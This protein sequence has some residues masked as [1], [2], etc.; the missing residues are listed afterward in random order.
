[1]VTVRDGSTGRVDLNKYPKIARLPNHLKQFMVD[2][3]Y[4]DYTPVDHA[5]WRYIMRQA[6]HILRE[7]AHRVYF[8]GLLDTGISLERIPRIEEMNEILGRIGWGAVAVDGFI[9]PAAFMEY[10]AY[11]VLVIACDMRQINHIEYT[12]APD[13]VHEAAGHA[14][15]IVDQEY[16]EYLR[17]FGEIGAKAMSSKKDFDLYEAI[18]LLS[19]LKE[20]P[21]ADAGEIRKAEE[22][23]VWLQNNLG[24]PSE[25]ARLSRLHWWTVEYGLIGDLSKS[26][27]YGAGLL[28]SIGEAVSCLED[29]VRKL[30]YAL[31][32]ADFAFDITTK[33]PQLFVTTDFEQLDRVLENFADSMA[34]RRGGLYGLHIAVEN[35]S[36]ATAVYSSGLQISGIFTE[37]I[38]SDGMPVY[39]RTTGS[40]TLAVNN[41]LLAGHGKDYHREGFGSPVGRLKNCPRPPESLDDSALKELGAELG[42]PSTLDFES[43][44]KVA[45]RLDRIERRNGF[46]ILVSFSDCTVTY[47]GLTLFEPSWGNY[48]MAVGE[49]IVSVF[50]GAA[51]KDA[52]E[53]VALVAK[54]RTIRVQN[55]AEDRRLHELYQLLREIREN[56][57]GFERLAGIWHTLSTDFTHDWLASLE[58]VEIL[59]T[60]Q[61]DP[62][63]EQEVRRSLAKAKAVRPELT[64]LI[65][66]GLR[67]IAES[68]GRAS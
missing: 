34:F 47:K 30:P 29:G 23:V 65:D 25:M 18:R 56:A 58:I 35:Q 62:S 36:T 60:N 2:Q 3:R 24:A 54:T 20:A 8:K 27:I 46:I 21:D 44:V 53:Q 57:A 41:K 63:L 51:D 55:S 17:K 1:M 66:D 39:V 4:D 32:A 49:R 38:E 11:Q 7:N 16:S 15:I 64:K 43:G 68:A 19:I 22:R 5:V 48:D 42:K 26:K 14:P 50:N 59:H 28:S 37:V 52:H 33:Q 40:T 13:I 12:P 45:G 31:E 10:Q 67:L 9:P 61:L 6:V